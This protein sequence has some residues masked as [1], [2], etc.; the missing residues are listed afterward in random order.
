M[1]KTRNRSGPLPQNRPS[2]V[3]LQPLSS[4]ASNMPL[5]DTLYRDVRPPGPMHRMQ[6]GKLGIVRDMI[7]KHGQQALELRSLE[8]KG[9]EIT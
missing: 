4:N 5:F 8:K 3:G 9:R 2:T 6:P 7:H 1:A